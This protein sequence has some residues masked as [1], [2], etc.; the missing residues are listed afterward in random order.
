MD[1]EK[2]ARDIIR[3]NTTRVANQ[4]EAQSYYDDSFTV[5]ITAPFHEVRTGSAADIVDNAVHHIEVANPQ[6]FREPQKNTAKDKES[7]LKVSRFLNFYVQSIM[8]EIIESVWNAVL[9]GEGIFQVDF[10]KD[11]YRQDKKDYVFSG[12]DL[13][14]LTSS[15]DPL[16][17]FCSPYDSLVPT[18]VVKQFEV[19]V[20][21]ISELYPDWSNPERRKPEGKTGVSYTAY[22]D[23]DTKYFSGDKQVLEEKKNVLGF[24]PFVH[25]YAGF[26]KRSPGG[27]PETMAVSILKKYMGTL[28][29]ECEIESRIDSII[30]IYANPV[31]LIEKLARDADETDK[32]RLEKTVIGPG[33]TII[34]GYGWKQTIYTPSVAT[35]ELFAH[36]GQIRERLGLANP[37][38]LS[39]VASSSRI[40]GRQEDIEYGHI[41]K[42]FVILTRN[43]EIALEGVIGMV[44]R[45]LDTQPQALPITVKG[46]V[47]D[48]E[49]KRIDK[50]SI[51]TI[52]KEDINGYYGCKVSL[53]PDKSLEDDQNFM[54]YRILVNEGRISWR[55]FLIEGCGKTEYEADEIIAE[56]LAEQAI[57][58]NPLLKAAREQEAIEQM[59]AD[60][61]VKK[62]QEDTQLQQRMQE[63]LNNYTPQKPGYR[64]SEARN[65]Q[66]AETVRQLL[67][68][69]VPVGIRRSPNA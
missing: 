66:A 59:G 19:D 39:G 43:L 10:N 49:G 54:K 12:E 33:Q 21:Q 18:K 20:D 17:V 25:F 34:T 56:A 5:G 26:G 51:L 63:E 23:K 6:V 45:I 29:E 41:R 32:E 37:P 11:A 46:E 44:L 35:G 48:E 8:P 68:G 50:E 14:V 62:A 38:I 9:R 4:E 47:K 24:C 57:M 27:D 31:L 1:I 15:P 60:R 64:P 13:P 52:T 3:R 22:Y 2:F 58:N 40:S 55:Q 61:F 28:K 30:G 67:G 53:N 42:R 7:A 69:E 36:L 16:T 65:P